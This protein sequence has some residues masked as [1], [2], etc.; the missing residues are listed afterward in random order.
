MPYKNKRY[1]R[2]KPATKFIRKK[3]RQGVS[4]MVLAGETKIQKN[5]LEMSEPYD[6]PWAGNF[7]T[8]PWQNIRNTDTLDL[9]LSPAVVKPVTIVPGPQP[10]DGNI[11]NRIGSFIVNG[12][13]RDQR[14][15]R[16]ITM[17]NSSMSF[18]FHLRSRAPVPP[19]TQYLYNL[20]PEFRVVQGWVKGGI[21]ALDLIEADIAGLYTEIPYARYKILYD[22]I[23]SRQALN[24]GIPQPD[25]AASY[26]KF[27]L[28]FKWVKNGRIMFD[29]SISGTGVPST[30]ADDCRYS[31][32]VPFVYFFN[33]HSNLNITFDNIKRL[34]IYK[35]I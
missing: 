17:L 16:R 30:N 31:G 9:V 23:L 35:D 3:K 20:N 13:E 34:N 24:S 22:K 28:N 10:D 26:K 5:I 4:K 15:G 19:E 14:N 8:T 18:V 25:A 6:T 1:R 29:K 11:Y 27:S 32:W 7:W 12:D 2:K 21:D 33:P